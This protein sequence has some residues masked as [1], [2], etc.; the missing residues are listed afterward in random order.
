MIAKSKQ[1]V[2]LAIP[3]DQVWE[4]K[5]MAAKAKMNLSDYLVN[6]AVTVSRMKPDISSDELSK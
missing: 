2:T 4:L 3:K 5:E 1:R 6:S